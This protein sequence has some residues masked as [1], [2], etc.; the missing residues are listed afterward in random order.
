MPAVASRRAPPST[1]PKLAGS[2]ARCTSTG[3]YSATFQRP[4]SARCAICSRLS[5]PRRAGTRP[6]E[7]RA[8]SSS[9]CAP[10]TN[11]P[12]ER[13]MRSADPCRWSVPRRPVMPQPGGR[14]TALHRRHRM[15]HQVLHEHAASLSAATHANRSHRLI[16]CAK[17]FGHY[18]MASSYAFAPPN[19]PSGPSRRRG[20]RC[21]PI[22][23]KKPLNCYC[24]TL[25]NSRH[26]ACVP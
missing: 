6:T 19:V 13:I 7:R 11:N 26:G 22:T 17:D 3:M 1:C 20:S 21:S 14:A 2:V 25:C 15:V 16:K 18:L 9:T 10:R 23:P 12:L 8:R 24:R 4:K 5:M